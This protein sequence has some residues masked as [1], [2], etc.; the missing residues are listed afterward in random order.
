[1]THD[2][3]HAIHLLNAATDLDGLTAARVPLL[4]GVLAALD[5]AHH[6][7]VYL[8]HLE[9]EIDQHRQAPA[10]I[11]NAGSCRCLNAPQPSQP[12]T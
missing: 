10:V 7:V 3:D 12:A 6:G 9:R 8:S 4:D 5:A 1:M 2:L 11:G